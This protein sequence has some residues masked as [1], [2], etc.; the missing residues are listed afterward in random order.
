MPSRQHLFRAQAL[1]EYA[2]S[3]EKDILP[4]L[5]RPPALL[6][7]WLLLSLLLIATLLAWHAQVPSFTLAAGVIV[8]DVQTA[9][10]GG[11]QATA[12]LF[13]PAPPAVNI[14]LGQPLTVQ[15]TG[16]TE[17]LSATIDSVAPGVITPEAARQR[18]GLTGDLAWVITQRSVVVTLILNAAPPSTALVGESVQAQIQ[19][20]SQSLLSLF[21]ELLQALF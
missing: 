16:Q 21:P 12:V 4:R 19:V 8:Q 11:S 10:Q 15:L 7:G 2:R 20:G 14:P 1:Q 13:V 17:P 9:P 18:Y 5:V 6:C 3:R